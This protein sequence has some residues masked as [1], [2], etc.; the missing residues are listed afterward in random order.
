MHQ[1][2]N[3]SE[4]RVHEPPYAVAPPPDWLEKAWTGAKQR[5][6]DKLTPADIDDEV[7][8]Y[9]RKSDPGPSGPP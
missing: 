6:L 8:A 5:G 3:V 7:A 9:R 4:A 2:I 1:L